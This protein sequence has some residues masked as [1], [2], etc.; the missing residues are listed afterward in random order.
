MAIKKVDLDES[1]FVTA[2]NRVNLQVKEV[3]EIEKETIKTQ[4]AKGVS[5]TRLAKI[6]TDAYKDQFK[7]VEVTVPGKNGQP[8]T[9]KS[10][11]PTITM[12]HIRTITET[13]EERQKRLEKAKAAKKA[14][15]EEK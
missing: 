15:A 3:L 6:L 1:L 2:T 11:K 9:K 5:N 14:K 4:Y 7:E 13:P 10:K 8:S 12:S